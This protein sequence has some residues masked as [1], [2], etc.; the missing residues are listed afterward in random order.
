LTATILASDIAAPG[1]PSITVF[2]PAPGGGTTSAISLSVN[3]PA[4]TLSTLS[5]SSASQGG[6]A[7]TLTLAGTGFVASSTVQVNGAPRT[8]TFVSATQLTASIPA[9]DLASAGTPSITISSPTPGGGTSSAL[10]FTITAVNPVPTLASLS[11]TSVLV[12]GPAFTLTATGT[13]FT[14]TSVVQVNGSPRVTTFGSATQL[15]ATILTSDIASAGT[16]SL[17]V[18]TPAPGGGTSAALALSVNNPAPTLAS[19]SPSSA[20]AGGPAF[21]LTATGTN[22]TPTSVVRVNG[23]NRATSFVSAAQLTAAILA[24]DIASAGTPSL[25][26]VT[27][28][29]GGGTSG[30]ATLTVTP[31]SLTVSATSVLPGASVT[32][33]LNNPPGNATDSIALALVRS[34]ATSSLQSVAVNTL[35]GTTSKAWT[36]TMPATPGQYEFWFFSS[37]SS[38]AAATSPAVTVVTVNPTPSISSL[39]PAGVT[40]GSAAFSLSVTGSGFV[41][42]ATAT[43]GGQARAV[44]FG[45]DKQLT[46]AVPAADV[47]SPGPAAVQVSNPAPCTGGLCASTSVA[48][49]VTAPTPATLTLAYNGKLRDR[50]GQSNTALAPDGALDGALTAT[51]SASGGRTVTGLRL[52][53]NAPGTWDTTSGTGFWVLAVAPTLDGT[54]L[55]APGTMTVNFPVPDGGSFVLFASDY[56]AAEFLPGRTL[57]LTATFSDGST[58]TATTTVPAT[59]TIAAVTPNQAAPGT[60]VPVTITGAGFAPGAAVTLSGANAG[61][62]ASTLALSG[63]DVTVSNVTV[64]SPTQL[65]ATLAFASTAPPGARNVIVANS[66]GGSGMLPGGVTV[67]GAPAALTLAYNG[68][69]RDRVGQGE[70]ALGPDG[71]PDGT[72]TATLSA[73]GGRTVTALRLDSNAPGVWDTTSG[74]IWW[75][76]GVAPSLDG[77]LLNA[78][79]TMAVTFPVA[80]GGSFVLFASDYLGTE[81]LAGRTLT[82]TATFSDGSTAIATTTVPATVTIA[83]VTPSQAAPGT[84]VP[85]TIAGTGFAPGAALSLSGMGTTVSNV[86]VVSATRLTAT[87]TIA[88]AAPSGARNV[89]VANLGGGGGML[90]GG[91]TVTRTPATLTLAYNG[92]LRDRVGQG[93]TALGP[94][95]ALDGTLT[96]TLSASGGRT[97]TALRLDSDAPGIWDT[98]SGNVWWALG[99]APWLDGALLNAPRTMAVNFP[100]ADGGS[101]VL[102]ASDYQATEFLPGRNLTLT[103]TFADG[104]TATAVTTVGRAAVTV[105][106]VAPNQGVS[107][108][109]MPV[110]ITNS[111]GGGGAAIEGATENTTPATLTLAYNGQLRDRVGQGNAALAPDGASDG[112]L[113][114]TLSAPGGRTI[115]GLRLDSNAPG[116]WDTSSGNVWWV[117]GVATTLDG[118]LLNAP[119]TMAVNFPVADGESFVV[120]ASDYQVSE[121]LPGQTLTLTATFADGSTATAVT[122]VP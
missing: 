42:G 104:S 106:S 24:T 95:G 48:L 46:I 5:P 88:G 66:S 107:G 90:P 63:P 108:A 12:G 97:V 38:V 53:S 99:V 120:F 60:T 93:E 73:G 102:F 82:L 71:A 77:A 43:V 57:T 49:T 65:A 79:G 109:A 110:T 92:K 59:V 83:S 28:T 111:G 72:L 101:F 96:A 44:T 11:P 50:V 40:A 105:T 14:A 35:P 33:T 74:N 76:L 18:V 31:P 75:A 23:V 121:F 68:K 115:T 45:S 103:A 1:T 58:A 89:T 32:A 34:P 19:L 22:F 30:A 37:N 87:L 41:T 118:A 55:N 27:P 98:T 20:T 100:V 21:T 25:T 2:T 84:T 112:T 116:I 54:L 113:T 78:P 8:T 7:F 86:S 6:P 52:D 94:D 67:T 62:T 114:A 70:T 4:P 10:A 85:V 64:K 29:P 119:G 61:G 51:L 47:A 15:T 17:A 13:N 91:L 69:L 36:V 117:S 122:T 56:Q 9:S 81:F 80:G 26:V 3:N 16:P 39:S